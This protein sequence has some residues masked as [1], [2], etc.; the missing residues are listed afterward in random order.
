[1]PGRAVSPGLSC[2][3]GRRVAAKGA[4]EDCDG[5]EVLDAAAAPISAARKVPGP[6]SAVLVTGITAARALGAVRCSRKASPIA[7]W[8]QVVF[9]LAS[10][11][12]SLV[13]TVFLLRFP[14]LRFDQSTWRV[15]NY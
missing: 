9:M 12:G 2:A 1:M 7:V 14:L 15:R 3:K 4:V 10:G 13:A 8:K 5:A 6:L 11:Y